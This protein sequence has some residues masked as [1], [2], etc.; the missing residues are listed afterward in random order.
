MFD[1]FSTGQECRAAASSPEPKDANYANQREDGKTQFVP[2]REIRVRP[3]PPF[4]PLTSD[5]VLL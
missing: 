2:I 5:F 4:C 3:T 1:V